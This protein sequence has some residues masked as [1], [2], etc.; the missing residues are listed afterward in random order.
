MQTIANVGL[1]ERWKVEAL[2]ITSQK[3]FHCAHSSG[4]CDVVLVAEIALAIFN[5]LFFCQ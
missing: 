5:T 3:K 2:A 1:I 4:F